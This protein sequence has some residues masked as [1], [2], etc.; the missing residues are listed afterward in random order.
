MRGWIIFII[1][2]VSLGVTIMIFLRVWYMC[3]GSESFLRSISRRAPQ[4]TFAVIHT[5]SSSPHRILP[6]A[7]DVSSTSRPPTHG[8][9]NC[10]PSSAI[11]ISKRR[12]AAASR[13]SAGEEL[14]WQLAA[15]STCLFG[16]ALEEGRDV[17]SV[18]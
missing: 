17:D 2:A 18:L 12:R 6:A 11:S 4:L 7:S 3:T 13:S 15:A 5:R 10:P 8:T 16:G 1:V 9:S 14:G